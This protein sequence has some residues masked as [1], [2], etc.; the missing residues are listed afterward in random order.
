MPKKVL[1]AD[2]SITIQKM[3][4]LSFATEDVVIESVTNGD[5]AIE[6]ARIIRPDIVL[7]DIFMP[8][9]NGYEVCETIK[10]DPQLS[11]I[12]VVLL[13]G[14]FEPFDEAEASR[15]K[16]DGCLKKP[17][18]SSELLETFH[19]LVTL[20]KS[21]STAEGSMPESSETHTPP[22]AQPSKR[23]HLASPRT[24]ESFI[25]SNKILDLFGSETEQQLRALTQA[26][27]S[28]VR[29]GEKMNSQVIAFPS[30]TEGAA[31]PVLGGVSAELVD[32]I[33]EKVIRRLS[34]D[35]VREVA[36]DVVPELAEI[37]IRQRLNERGSTNKS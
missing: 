3:V 16:S 10:G 12:P 26:V 6:K 35:V 25:G 31:S 37:M 5:H 7:A 33:V 13:V 36:W 4:S 8:G 19:A 30:A 17:F 18:D 32:A 22:D 29:V 23:M 20:G 11:H 14:T 27:E 15:V 24:V 28:S 1:I 9:R 34:Q 2:D 21:Q